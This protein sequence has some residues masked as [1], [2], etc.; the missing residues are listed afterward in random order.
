MVNLKC[1]PLLLGLVRTEVGI[2]PAYHMNKENLATVAL[3][4]SAQDE[5]VKILLD[6]SFELTIAKTRRNS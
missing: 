5:T 4:G 1:D 2:F 6:V 3:N